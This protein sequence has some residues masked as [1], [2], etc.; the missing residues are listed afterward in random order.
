MLAHHTT[1]RVVEDVIGSDKLITSLT[2]E[3]YCELLETL[4]WFPVNVTKN[5]GDIRVRDAAKAAKS[6]ASI[7]TINATML[8]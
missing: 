3:D 6:D 1:R 2:R 7:R 5:F 8:N 4:R